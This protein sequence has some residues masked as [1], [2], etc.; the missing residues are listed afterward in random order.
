MHGFAIQ[1][2]RSET[3]QNERGNYRVTTL[4]TACLSSPEAVGLR[5]EDLSFDDIPAQSKLFREYAR[6]ATTLRRFYPNAVREH[7][8]LTA[9]AKQV[10]AAYT[11]DR[12]R[13][14]D[15][16]ERLNKS[17]DAGAATIEN[18]ARL[19]EP[20]CV[21]VVT[22]QQAGLFT[23]PLYTIYKALSAVKLARCLT[24]RGTHAVPVF[25][26]AT[27]DHDWAEVR[28][29]EVIGCDGRLATC[30]LLNELH[31]EGTPVGT[32]T[33]DAS[34]EAATTRLLDI[35]PTTEF[36]TSIAEL[37]RDS[38][39]PGRDFGSAFARMM[40]R[41]TA[42]FGIIFVDPLDAELKRFAATVYAEA[43]RHATEIA[44]ALEERSRLLEAEGYHAQ[45][46]ATGDSFP[47]F[48]HTN[49]DETSTQTPA[50]HALTRT[51]EGAYAAKG[52]REIDS[53][54]NWARRAAAHPER[55]SPNVTLRSVVQDYLLPTVA[56]LGGA[57][58][59]AYFA[60]TAEVYRILNRPV[61]PI[62]HRASLTIIEKRTSRTLER[63]DLHLRDFFAG[64]DSV[65]KRVVE[66]YLGVE[67]SRS[68][69]ETEKIIALA[70]ADL[71]EQLG[72]VDPTL[73][74]ALETREAKINYQLEALRTRFTRA[75][76]QRDRAAHRQLE[77]A[78]VA[79]YPEHALQERHVNITSLL[80][81]H[82]SYTLDWLYDA[83]DLSSVKHQI[84][85]L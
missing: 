71:R 33:L 37:L 36:S 26:I 62:L 10:L 34:I 44:K 27:E 42:Q 69:D 45:V 59:I 40:M 11:T 5:L 47:L 51:A 19:R 78:A 24:G 72:R 48:V 23:G 75:Q 70:L 16:L 32:L 1:E 84:V 56:Y 83:I 63:Y 53:A 55:F 28:A 9:H 39:A 79:L 50:R 29:A 68:F 57:A 46:L 31:T 41:L 54:E 15:A 8:E 2:H 35:L 52:T 74:D 21:A 22:G 64:L 18:I 25:W 81:R 13:L 82:G 76:M 20:D 43:A 65:I 66:K 85:Y 49:D 3:C 12:E 61:T 58:E 17:Y 60:Q 30:E 7:R 77:R 38:Y 4:E 73:V 80:A 67:G 6:D 14:C